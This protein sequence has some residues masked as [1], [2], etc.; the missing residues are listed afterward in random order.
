MI[1]H[2]ARI[3]VADGDAHAYDSD[4]GLVPRHQCVFTPELVRTHGVPRCLMYHRLHPC[5][6]DERNCLHG[7]SSSKKQQVQK[8]KATLEPFGPENMAQY[9]KSAHRLGTPAFICL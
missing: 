4:D 9:N 3:T 8:A 1:D 5:L 6:L 2:V 7:S